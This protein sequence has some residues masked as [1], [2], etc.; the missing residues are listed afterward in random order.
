M[1]AAHLCCWH[2]AGRTHLAEQW[3]PVERCSAAALMAME[4]LSGRKPGLRR[5]M[6]RERWQQALTF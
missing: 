2:S 1:L 4:R 5:A 6:R 3:W